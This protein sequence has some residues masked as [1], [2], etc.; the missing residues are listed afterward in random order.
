M[1]QVLFQFLLF[2]IFLLHCSTTS[3]QSPAEAPAAPPPPPSGPVDIITI[4]KKAGNFITFIR[5]LKNTELAEQINAQVKKANPGI[6]LFAP[7]DDAFSDLKE[8]T[9]NSLTDKKQLQLVQFHMLPAYYSILQFQ[10]ATNPMQTQAGF[11]FN[12]TCSDTQVNITTGVDGATLENTLFDNSHL[13]VY[14]VDHVLLPLDLFGSA[15]VLTP[16]KPETSTGT[17]DTPTTTPTTT[18]ET[19]DATGP[20]PHAVATI[21]FGVAVGAIFPLWL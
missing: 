21:A 14:Q 13:A 20:N 18:T 10:T 15:S 9:L 5:L 2:L 6:T 11:Q 4:L 17:D 1:K 8:G 12:V 7:K 19:S 3:A 16:P